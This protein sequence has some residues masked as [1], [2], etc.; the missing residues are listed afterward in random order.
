MVCS[1]VIWAA[2]QRLNAQL[3]VPA[4]DV[5]ES[6]KARKSAISEEV[7]TALR[8]QRVQMVRDRLVRVVQDGLVLASGRH[9]PADVIILCTGY[10]IQF[11][12]L[13]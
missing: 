11:Q 12:L 1:T 5:S 2:V 9:L 8:E 6:L 7:F 13:V 4:A 10:E 3:G